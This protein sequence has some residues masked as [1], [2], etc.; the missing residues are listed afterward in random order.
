MS[1]CLIHSQMTKVMTMNIIM[2]T[3]PRSTRM[4]VCLLHGR[5]AENKNIA[6]IHLYSYLLSCMQ[7]NVEDKIFAGFLRVLK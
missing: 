2:Q 7:Y 5:P 6:L 3:D 1:K 4:P